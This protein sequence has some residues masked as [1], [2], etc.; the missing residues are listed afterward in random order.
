MIA[1]LAGCGGDRG[2]ASG[3]RVAARPPALPRLAAQPPHSLSAAHDVSRTASAGDTMPR[4]GAS[5][6]VAAQTTTL[7]V[8]VLR[9]LDPLEGSG[10]KVPP[11][12]RAVGVLVQI[13]DVGAGGYDSSATA[14]I[15][16][17]AADRPATPMFVPRGI[18]QTPLRD[19]DNEIGPGEQ[20]EGCVTFAVTD[21]QRPLIVS[22][23]PH[24]MA[25]G[26][27]SWRVDG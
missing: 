1:A 4:V 10:A 25:R 17:A 7:D 21:G 6:R 23:F 19:F 3:G 5:Q 8:R 15:R 18:C 13:S 11:D 26:S 2:R 12:D 9:V 20:R 16:L 24:G 27:V 22:F 14:D